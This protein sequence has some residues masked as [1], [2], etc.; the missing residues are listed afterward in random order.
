MSLTY[1]RSRITGAGLVAA[2]Y[3]LTLERQTTMDNIL[4]IP[5][6]A[7]PVSEIRQLLFGQGQPGGSWIPSLSAAMI[8]ANT[9]GSG[10]TDI[11]DLS[12][13]N[14]PFSQATP[15]SRG[16]WFREPKRGRVN[17][18][19]NSTLAATPGVIGSGGSYAG[20]TNF[21]GCTAEVIS[22]TPQ[23][24]GNDVVMRISGTPTATGL[25][26]IGLSP[27]NYE[28]LGPHIGSCFLQLVAGDF[29][30]IGSERVTLVRT[31]NVIFT[32]APF[33]AADLVNYERRQTSAGEGN[34]SGIL[35]LQLEVTS[36]QPVDF[37]IRF[38]RPQLE[39]GSVVTAYQR[40]DSEFNITEQGQRDCYGVRADGI[41]DRYNTTNNVNFT[42]TNKMTVFAAV[43]KRSDAARGVIVSHNENLDSRFSL[44]SP[45]TDP[46][47]RALYRSRGTATAAAIA[48]SAA[49]TA[50]VNMVMT[51]E[52]DIGS[53]FARLRI[54]GASVA[55]VT[56]NQGTGNYANAALQLFHI[57]SSGHFNGD[58]F[59]I[60]IAGGSYPL[61][62]IQRVE[63]ILSRITPTVNL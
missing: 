60:I 1:Q 59:A 14:N 7:N 21:R 41:D 24:Y 25:L 23:D 53:P 46:T 50:P 2:Q 3:D 26:V 33:A 30:N 48:T 29:T 37:T 54:N 39:G 9:F 38:S 11:L 57:A 15:S 17:R 62:T 19:S 20:D 22:V 12:G 47:F 31:N 4:F 32:N 6:I 44:E 58:M 45:D 10:V 42:A 51:G 27:G 61:S 5:G 35:R 56:V 13:N 36:G 43:R 8:A 52:S 18:Q 49:F 40:V 63:R 28:S 34:G 55:N 16:A